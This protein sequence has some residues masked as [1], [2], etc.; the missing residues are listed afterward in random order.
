VD[1]F[2]DISIILY[3]SGYFKLKIS[4]LG[5]QALIFLS[6][7]TR[8]TKYKLSSISEVLHILSDEKGFVIF[9]SIANEN[10]NRSEMI[11]TKFKLTRK[12]YYTRMARLIKT[13][14]IKKEKG[15][16]FLTAFGR[17]VHRAQFLTEIGLKNY[18]KLRAV[19]SLGLS[20][21]GRLPEDERHKIIESLIDNKEIK[22][23]LLAHN[24][25]TYSNSKTNSG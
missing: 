1:N 6:L 9:K 2:W 13:G 18:W 15:I 24:S 25:N 22:E 16:Y 4:T 20:K 21:D 17:V 12:Q 10:E 19:D 11:R 23:L 3:L 8:D 7:S 5:E 14:L